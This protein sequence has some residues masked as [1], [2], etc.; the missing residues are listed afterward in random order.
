MEEMVPDR[1]IKFEIFCNLHRLRSDVHNR[2]LT[3][4][5]NLKLASG[6]S[7]QNGDIDGVYCDPHPAAGVLKAG[8]GP[9]RGPTTLAASS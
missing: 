8:R 6:T 7:F 5:D 1:S 4:P 9:G 3:V 2:L